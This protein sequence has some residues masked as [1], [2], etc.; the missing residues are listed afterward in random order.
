MMSRVPKKCE[1]CNE[2]FWCEL[3]LIAEAVHGFRRQLVKKIQISKGL[4]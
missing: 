1:H 2:V 4:K 3:S